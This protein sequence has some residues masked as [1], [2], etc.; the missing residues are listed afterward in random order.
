M[1]LLD[2]LVLDDL[3]EQIFAPNRLAELLQGYL[4][5]AADWDLLSAAARRAAQ[6]GVDRNR[7]RD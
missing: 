2:D 1:G 5:Q 6:S 4:D 3:A 7:R